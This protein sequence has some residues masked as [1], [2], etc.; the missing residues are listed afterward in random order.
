VPNPVDTL[1]LQLNTTVAQVQLDYWKHKPVVGK[2]LRKLNHPPKLNILKLTYTSN[3]GEGF[4]FTLTNTR[5]D[6]YPTK[7][8][9]WSAG[10]DNVVRKADRRSVKNI[11]SWWNFVFSDYIH[12]LLYVEFRDR[13]N[14]LYFYMYHFNNL[15]LRYFFMHHL[16]MKN[17]KQVP[18]LYFIRYNFLIQN[19]TA[20]KQRHMKKYKKKGLV[21]EDRFTRR[22]FWI[23]S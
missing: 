8:Q 1:P 12:D 6:D 18:S 19:Y 7:F 21:H 9:V 13:P 4:F 14:F 5:F 23:A 3:V 15:T 16:Y 10:A 11:L 20:K 22:E 2:E 17:I